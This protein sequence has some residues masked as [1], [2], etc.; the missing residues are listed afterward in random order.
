MIESLG[1]KAICRCCSWKSRRLRDRV[2]FPTQMTGFGLPDR[3]NLLSAA[4]S[5]NLWSLASRRFSGLTIS[6]G[7]L[8]LMRGKHSFKCHCSKA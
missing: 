5:I 7:L 2:G 3:L 6:V 1:C 8:L 4:R